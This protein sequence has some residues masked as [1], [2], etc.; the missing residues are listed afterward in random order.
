MRNRAYFSVLLFV[1]FIFASVSKIFALECYQC[2][3]G[4]LHQHGNT[5]CNS[6]INA[7]DFSAWKD[8]YQGEGND[9]Q[10]IDFNCS[11][12]DNVHLI[13]QEDLSILIE[14]YNS[15]DVF[16]SWGF[17][18]LGD[19]HAN[20]GNYPYQV[21]YPKLLDQKPAMVFHVGDFAWW[22]STKDPLKGLLGLQYWK[23]NDSTISDELV[24]LHVAPG[25][26]DGRES[27]LEDHYLNDVCF[28]KHMS[29][30][31]SGVDDV[32]DPFNP[33]V[34][35]VPGYCESGSQN[36]QYVFTRGNIR[37]IMLDMPFDD[38]GGKLDWFS[39]RICEEN[40]QAVTIAFL[41]VCPRSLDSKLPKF[42]RSVKN[43]CPDNNLKVVFS[44]HCHYFEHLYDENSGVHMVST[45]G[46]RWGGTQWV[47]HNKFGVIDA[48]VYT[49]KIVFKR[50]EGKR[51]KVDNLVGPK[52]FLTIPGEFS[53]YVYG[54]QD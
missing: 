27:S 39:E 32:R 22:A 12:N 8:I 35:N 9:S 52:E 25:N 34:Q 26:H 54:G 18:I 44:G 36:L 49:D 15:G 3:S 46:I 31:D 50:W 37:F 21:I 41:H 19:T 42:L 48:D 38:R 53:N 14:N 5:D 20:H 33:E 30:R 17:S 40:D 29:T 51:W 23:Q 16:R 11:L 10:K 28:G 4:K 43:S 47:Q 7:L 45:H 1:L 24:E 2:G 6:E 13:S